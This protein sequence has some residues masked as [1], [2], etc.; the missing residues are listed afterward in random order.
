MKFIKVFSI[1]ILLVSL[2]ACS[3]FKEMDKE[4]FTNNEIPEQYSINVSQEKPS[5]FMGIKAFEDN[6]L[7]ILIHRAMYNNLT[8]ESTRTQYMQAKAQANIVGAAQYPNLNVS[9]EP[10]MSKNRNLSSGTNS[11]KNN[12]LLGMMSSF[13]LDFWG[14]LRAQKKAAHFSLTAAELD[15][16]TAMISLISEISLCWLD[17]ISQ[18]MQLELLQKQLATNRMYLK[19]IRLRFQKGMVGALDVYQK[20]QVV[21]SILSQIPLIDA[22][23]HLRYNQM[24][25]LCGGPPQAKLNISRKQFPSL[26]HLPSAGVP[27]DLLSN[28]P[29]IRASWNRL[30]ASYQNVWIAKARQLPSLT[31]S[32]SGNFDSEKISNLFDAWFVRLAGQLT[33]PIFDAG[34][35]REETKLT[36]AQ[37]H[38]QMIQYRNIVFNAIK[39][40]EDALIQTQQQKLHINALQEEE[41]IAQ[42]ALDEARN[43]YQ[44]G[45]NDYLPVLTHILTVQRLDR[46]I[47][48]QSAKYFQYYV[49]LY[50][51][52]GGQLPQSM[53]AIKTGDSDE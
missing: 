45:L 39:E 16:Q 5:L 46:E 34:R 19:L 24:A 7:N 25:I 22:Q 6:E 13:E 14:K 29:D 27:S 43:R 18:N 23:V 9:V 30:Q 48:Q 42:K 52:L 3:F 32:A 47:I 50:R 33:S 17:I 36:K 37:A 10:S 4:T 21:S 20:Q 40:V 35:L 28:R 2:F 38:A 11:W 31:L 51:A 8:L 44:K 49:Y 53:Y 15:Y 1:Q 26:D 12:F 41:A